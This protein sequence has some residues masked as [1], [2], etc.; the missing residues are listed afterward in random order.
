MEMDTVTLPSYWASALI[1]GDYSS[2]DAQEGARVKAL[3][4]QYAKEG[5]TFEDCTDEPRFTWSYDLYDTGATCS[6]GE[7]LDY[8]VLRSLK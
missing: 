6:G 4:A 8:T 2:L 5:W 1:N 7:V 3:V